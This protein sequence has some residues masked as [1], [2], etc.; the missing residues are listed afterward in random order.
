M[1]SSSAL[2]SISA[3]LR[4]KDDFSSGVNPASSKLF[5]RIGNN[6]VLVNYAGLS[7]HSELGDGVIMSGHSGIHQFT[8]IGR[9]AMLSGGV[10][11]TM[12]VPPFC[13][14]PEPNRI[15]GI[16]MVGM[17]RA[18]I[19]RE[20]ITMVRRAFRE[21][22]RGNLQH[23]EMIEILA[24]LGEQSPA[25]KEM[26]DFCTSGDRAICPGP[27]RPPRLIGT[28]LRSL[29]KGEAALSVDDE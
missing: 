7:G 4:E 10:N 5:P 22:L 18:G 26:H 2:A 16:N 6:C 15:G 17:R 25:V 8:R 29:K 13:M 1:P 24:R 12:D 9:L 28:W 20:E 19:A 27:L 11:V 14:A 21:A 23:D 3:V